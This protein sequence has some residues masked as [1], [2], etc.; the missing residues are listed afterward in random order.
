M[1]KGIEYLKDIILKDILREV[2]LNTVLIPQS[3]L[4]E[5]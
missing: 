3:W 2:N 5:N 1:T 4:L